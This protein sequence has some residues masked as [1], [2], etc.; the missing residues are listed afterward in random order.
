MAASQASVDA[1]KAEGV[2]ALIEY[3]TLD[4]SDSGLQYAYANGKFKVSDDIDLT[5]IKPAKGGSKGTIE[6]WSNTNEIPKMAYLYVQNHPDF[7]YN[8]R[9]TIKG[10]GD[11]YLDGLNQALMNGQADIYGLESAFVAKYTQGD[12]AKFAAPYDSLGIDTKNAVS[13]ADI[14]NYIV[15]IGTRPTDG[16]IVAL[17]YNSTGGVFIYRRSIAKE[18]WG[19]DDPAAVKEKIGGGSG[20]WDAYWNAAEELKAH[21]YA[22]CSGDD[23]WPVVANSADK[24]WIVDGKLYIDPKREEFF[25]IAKKLEDNKYNNSTAQWLDPWF[26]DMKGKGEKPVFG[27]FGPSWFINYTLYDNCGN[28]PDRYEYIQVESV[29]SNAVLAKSD[30]APEFLGNQDMYDVI[31]PANAFAKGNNVTEYDETLDNLFK[32]CV[33]SYVYG[34]YSKEECIE[35]F[36]QTANDAYGIAIN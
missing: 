22:I 30:W 29:A 20:S 36:M 13:K 33:R 8:I 3:I 15:E 32:A 18:V 12:M 25:D 11:G 35:E 24:G 10:V 21:G 2:K 4:Y 31:I 1:G 7:D 9:V 17:G 28:V 16:K 26:A 23:M 19:T 6:L 5:M 34:G 14:A 27:Y